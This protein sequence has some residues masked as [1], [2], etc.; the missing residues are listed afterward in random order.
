MGQPRALRQHGR[1]AEGHPWWGELSVGM[2]TT[3]LNLE[4]PEIGIDKTR[5]TSSYLPPTLEA[6]ALHMDPLTLITSALAAGAAVAG[7]EA[8][9]QGVKD[10]YAA[11]KR[12][13]TARFGEKPGVQNA[14]EQ[15]EKKPDSEARQNVLKEELQEA[16]AH[17]DADLVRE[18]QTLLDL[19]KKERL[20]SA[21][22][23][24]AYQTGSGGL[25]QGKGA[26]AAGQG[27]VVAGR[28]ISMAPTP[29]PERP[30]E[31]GKP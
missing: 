31:Q 17:E 8:V 1:A 12:G 10:A 29:V 5:Q 13:I 27:G 15:V 4:S 3:V 11:L 19:L 23:Y 9:T 21:E 2:D 24:Q 25:A 26:A 30:S 18:A 16:N 20:V 14:V 7:K 22:S 6:K 28:D